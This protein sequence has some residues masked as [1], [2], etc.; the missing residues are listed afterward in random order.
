MEI[1]REINIEIEGIV[2]LAG[3]KIEEKFVMLCKPELVIYT[4]Q[5]FPQKTF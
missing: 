1:G 2:K 3:P 4:L 5:F